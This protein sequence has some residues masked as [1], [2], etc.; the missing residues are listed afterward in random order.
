M[1]LSRNSL[2]YKAMSFY[3]TPAENICGFTRQ[4]I[5]LII[6]SFTVLLGTVGFV[7]S[8]CLGLY[9]VPLGN[10]NGLYFFLAL[11]SAISLVVVICIIVFTVVIFIMD[12]IF[13]KLKER[14]RLNKHSKILSEVA[15]RLNPIKAK[16]EKLCIKIKY[17]D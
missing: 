11:F 12:T 15:K 14:R 16:A 6:T 17:T 8:L 3:C 13:E 2:L 1:E 7:V 4:L 5:P 10:L 9:S